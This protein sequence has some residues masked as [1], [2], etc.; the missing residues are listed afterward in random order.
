MSLR[1][2][3]EV[4]AGSQFLLSNIFSE[5]AHQRFVS[6]IT[7]PKHFMSVSVLNLSTQQAV[8]LYTRFR[9]QF[10]LLLNNC[11]QLDLSYFVN[12]FRHLI[13]NLGTFIT[14]SW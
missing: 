7:K 9:M 14:A 11:T 1:K 6:C 12:V 3:A 5:I 13:Q 2:R 8:G 4:Q 10:V